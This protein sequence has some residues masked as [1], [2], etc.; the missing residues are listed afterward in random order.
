MLSTYAPTHCGLATFTAALSDALCANGADVSVVRVADGAPSSSE[1]VVGEL[2]SGSV[3][4]IAATSE[5][6]NQNDVAVIQHE[7]G[8]YG[9][10]D[11]DDVLDIIDGL[12]VPS[13]VVAHTV[14]KNPTPHQR[15]VLE[16]IAAMADQVVVM[17]EAARRRLCAGFDVDSRKVTTIPHGAAIP[18]GAAAKRP[19]RPTLLTW[20]LL[21]PGKGVERVIESMTSLKDLPGR[22]QYLIAGRTHPKVLADHGESY[23]D[24]RKDQARRRGVA[25]SVSFDPRY[26]GVSK[27]PALIQSASVVVLPYDSTDQVTSGVLVDAIACGR[28][29]VATAFPHA[30]ELLGTGAGIVVDHDDP[31]AMAL[32]L[33]Q[34]LTQPRLAGS[35]AGEARRLAPEMAWSVVASA[36]LSLADRLHDDRRAMV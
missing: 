34:V 24:A 1:R 14:L 32:A 21:G 17:S 25:D 19:S 10:V 11:G 22:P 2:L 7:Y 30:V 15:S 31:D 29:V 16:S 27:L 28:P 5:L 4:S 13:I 35:M 6:L 36:Y 3:T 12:R 9:G 8:I 26:W 33:R 23:R 18:K 20:G